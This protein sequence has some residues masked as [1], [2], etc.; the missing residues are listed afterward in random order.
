MNCTALP[1]SLRWQHCLLLPQLQESRRSCCPLLLPADQH[2]SFELTDMPAR[3]ERAHNVL[4]QPCGY[5]SPRSPNGRH[6]ELPSLD[7]AEG[8][9]HTLVIAGQAWPERLTKAQCWLLNDA[10]KWLQSMLQP[11]SLREQTQAWPKRR[12]ATTPPALA[13]AGRRDALWGSCLARDRQQE[14]LT[15]C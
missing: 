15:G 5:Q 2:R 9:H 7:A 13:L 1:Q 3:A 10:I 14:A 6:L 8:P 12:D 11:S 4:P